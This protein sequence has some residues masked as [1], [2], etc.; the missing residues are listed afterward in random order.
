MQTTVRLPASASLPQVW[1][2]SQFF[3]GTDDPAIATTLETLQAD[4]ASIRAACLPFIATADASSPAESTNLIDQASAIYQQR[5]DIQKRLGNVNTYIYTALSTDTQDAS[6]NTWMPI[7]QKLSADLSEALT[8]YNVFLLRASEDF[9]TALLSNPNLTET[10]FSIH[11]SRKLKDQLLSVAEEQLITGLATNGLH[12]WGNLYSE[13]AGSL[14]C[15]IQGESMGLA[16]AANLLSHPKPETRQ[17]A[18]EGIRDAW[19]DHQPA[20]AA[21]LNAING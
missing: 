13:L 14:K 4:I 20:I 7:L 17:A 2:N 9:I 10:A 3:S 12:A 11:H 15:E 6:A 19:S 16:Q 5:Q 18:W 21:G 1:D 8:P